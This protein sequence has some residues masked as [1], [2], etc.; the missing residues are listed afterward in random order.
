MYKATNLNFVTAEDD[1]QFKYPYIEG[2]LS[3]LC[4]IQTMEVYTATKKKQGISL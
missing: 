2:Q 4:Y 3:K 1:K